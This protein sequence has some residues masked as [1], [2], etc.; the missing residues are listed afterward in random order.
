MSHA[1]IKNRT[2]ILRKIK[3]E[4]GACRRCPLNQT[5]TKVVFGIGLPT[6]KT[7]IISEAPGFWEDQKGLPFVGRAGKLLD[8][9]LSSIGV[10]R[11]EIYITNIVK[12]HPPGN[13]KPKKEEIKAC[14]PY[15]LKQIEIIKPKIIVCLGRVALNVFLPKKLLSKIHG[16]LQQFKQFKFFPTFHPAA[17]LRFPKIKKIMEEDFKKLKEFL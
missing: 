15:L 7:M 8:E 4:V 10:K 6:T 12:C 3:Q 1:S 17:A 9:L 11:G 13:R 16:Q 5:R 14:L 2:E